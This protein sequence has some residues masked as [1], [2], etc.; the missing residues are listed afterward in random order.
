MRGRSAA[1]SWVQQCRRLQGAGRYAHAS[2]ALYCVV[3]HALMTGE[4]WWS[5]GRAWIRALLFGARLL[6]T[7]RQFR[8]DWVYLSLSWA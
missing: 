2:V 5:Y 3:M 8:K 1:R 7:E 4:D 6:Q